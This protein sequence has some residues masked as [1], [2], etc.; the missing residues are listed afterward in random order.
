MV[1]E[2]ELHRLI[3]VEEVLREKVPGLA[4]RMPR[5]VINYL[6]R[7]I[8]Q[9]EVNEVLRRYRDK[10]GVDFMTELIQYFD[11]TLKLTGEENIPKEGRY[12]YVSN[13]PLGGLDGVCL[14]AVL[15]KYYNGGIRYLVNDILLFI[16]NL[17]SIFIP[18]NK[19]GKQK[20]QTAILTDE[21]YASD[22]QI[23][24]F[25]AGLC[26][27]KIK[28]EITDLPWKKSFIQKAVEYRRDVI[29]VYFEGRNSAFFYRLANLRMK[30]GIKAN[31][32]MLYLSD[33]LFRSKHTSF[34]IYLGKPI[35]WQ[36][37]DKSKPVS[38]WVEWVRTLAYNLRK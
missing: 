25:P 20:K 8:H 7:I 23:I 14:S 32:E 6:I 28:G 37:F 19:H 2:E 26:S 9:D 11:I 36:T 29:P 15:G 10:D 27:R 18:I 12:I 4:S 33:E 1:K 16:P 21:A 3:N 22:N 5:F 17:R 31:L 24:T 35:P 38:E 34:H 13:H 30:L